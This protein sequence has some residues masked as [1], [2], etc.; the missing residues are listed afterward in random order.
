MF[1]KSFL[2]KAR[3]PAAK[4]ATVPTTLS[5]YFSLVAI[6]IWWSVKIQRLA[7]NALDACCRWCFTSTWCNLELCAVSIQPNH[8]WPELCSKIAILSPEGSCKCCGGCA[9][10]VRTTVLVAFSIKPTCDNAVTKS[11]KSET[12]SAYDFANNKMSSAKRRSSNA[13][14]PSP[15]SNPFKEAS[16][17]QFFI[18][19][20]NTAENKRGLRTHPCLTPEVMGKLRLDPHLPC[21]SPDWPSYSFDSIHIMWSE[22]PWARNAFQ[23]VG[24]CTRSKAFERSKLTN[25]TGIP[26]AV[27][28]SRNKLAVSR[29]SSSRYFER[30]PCC[31]SGW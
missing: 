4:H 12:A 3:C 28:L 29:C 10:F 31:S 24:Q 9:S 21:T 16:R 27:A 8:F 25:Q 2:Y 6:D 17:L 7:K 30:N 5:K 22:M 1:S 14:S 11:C 26:C 18:A 23:R 20:C 19:H 15:K 13:G